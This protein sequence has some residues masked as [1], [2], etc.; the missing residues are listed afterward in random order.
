M[1]TTKTQFNIGIDGSH[2]AA[3]TLRASS[4]FTSSL[5][6]NESASLLRGR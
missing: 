3:E 5:R 2:S 6:R 4:L 1:N